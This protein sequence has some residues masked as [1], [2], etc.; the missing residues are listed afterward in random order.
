[1]QNPDHLS[2]NTLSKK[3]KRRLRLFQTPIPNDYHWDELVAVMT[4][5]GF[6]NECDGGSHYTFEHE[7]G[8]R[9]MISRTHPTGILKHYQ[10]KNARQALNA[11][12]IEG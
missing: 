10:I 9:V 6:K 4:D 12:G 7:S 1:L 5:A 11:I 2:D 8:L 3:E